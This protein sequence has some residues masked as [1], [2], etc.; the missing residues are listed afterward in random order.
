MINSRYVAISPAFDVNLRGVSARTICENDEFDAN[1]RA[2]SARGCPTVVSEIKLGLRAVARLTARHRR[3]HLALKTS[4]P[5]VLHYF[6]LDEVPQLNFLMYDFGIL[7]I[8]R[9]L[10]YVFPPIAGELLHAV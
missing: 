4:A 8:A 7:R 3:S 2:Q 5:V 6:V 9:V 10:I 1:L